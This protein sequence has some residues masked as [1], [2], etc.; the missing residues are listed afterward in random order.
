[1]TIYQERI[2]KNIRKSIKEIALSNV[3]GYLLYIT[4]EELDILEKLVYYLNLQEEAIIQTENGNANIVLPH[5]LELSEI[6]LML[7]HIKKEP[8]FKKGAYHINTA[9]K[10]RSAAFDLVF[11]K[12]LDIVVDNDKDIYFELKNGN[13][14]K[15]LKSRKH[16]YFHQVID[17][18]KRFK[19]FEDNI[20]PKKGIYTFDIFADRKTLKPVNT[21]VVLVDYESIKCCY[22]D[23]SIHFLHKTFHLNITEVANLLYQNDFFEYRKLYNILKNLKKIKYIDDYVIMRQINL[24][25]QTGQMPFSYS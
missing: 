8:I 11:N 4:G 14:L 5:K 18:K 24:Y 9:L 2:C 10:V 12:Y 25:E 20:P 13:F 21:N 16:F 19:G 7:E 22:I 23:L 15:N 6:D 1:M 3:T 17:G